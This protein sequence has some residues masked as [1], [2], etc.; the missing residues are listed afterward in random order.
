MLNKLSSFTDEISY[1]LKNFRNTYEPYAA[2]INDFFLYSEIG[3]YQ[4][5]RKDLLAALRNYIIDYWPDLENINLMAKLSE[6]IK[7]AQ[8]SV[9]VNLPKKGIFKASLSTTLKINSEFFIFCIEYQGN[10]QKF[11]VAHRKL[12]LTDSEN[13]FINMENAESFFNGDYIVYT[14]RNG[15]MFEQ[16]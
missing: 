16:P 9:A 5:H 11:W 2:E 4:E 10:L 12:S 15:N 6:L 14:L 7:L 8:K 1:D 13:A 3:I